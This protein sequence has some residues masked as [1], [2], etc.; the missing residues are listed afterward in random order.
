MAL[1][2]ALLGGAAP[3][4]V[5]GAAAAGPPRRARAGDGL[6][7]LR[8]RRR[9]RPSRRARRARR[10]SA[11]WSS[12]GT[13][14][15]AT[16]PR[17][18]SPP[19]PAVLFVSIHQSPL[20]PGTGPASSS[21]TGAGEGFTVNLPVPGGSG[22][23]TLPLAGRARRRAADP[24]RGSRSS[25][26][27]RRASTPTA[28]TRSPTCQVTEAGFAGDDRVGAAGG[29]AS[30]ARRSALVLEGGYD[31]GALAGSMAALMPVLAASRARGGGRRAASAG[32]RPRR[33]WR[34]GGPLSG[35]VTCR[36][37]RPSG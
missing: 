22:D 27:S 10:S 16:A 6:L 9:S 31:L 15:T 23:A 5:L 14:T 3:T 24:R 29:D 21:G 30:S 11:C 7:P 35:A 28:T 33:G 32:A 36:R 18:S 4:G 8:Q 34:R 1:V 2:D 13:C 20:Y 19:T 25:C 37:A 26:S 12:T 17:R